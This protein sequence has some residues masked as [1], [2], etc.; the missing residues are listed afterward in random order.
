MEMMDDMTRALGG[1]GIIDRRDLSYSAYRWLTSDY[2]PVAIQH[3]EQL[4]N[5]ITKLLS[6]QPLSIEMH[7]PPLDEP[8]SLSER[9]NVTV[10]GGEIIFPD[11]ESLAG[12]QDLI[13]SVD[14]T[15]YLDGSLEI[16]FG[17]EKP[18]NIRAED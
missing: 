16:C 10:R 12:L 18:I 2:N 3:L 4:K 13:H 8:L 6:S 11:P 14:I 7:I 5:T 1:R 17:S 15:P 9:G